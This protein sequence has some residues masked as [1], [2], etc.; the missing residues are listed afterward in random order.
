MRTIR[1]RTFF[2][3]FRD[4]TQHRKFPI[5]MT[6]IE[7]FFTIKQHSLAFSRPHASRDQ[8]YRPGERCVHAQRKLAWCVSHLISLA[9]CI[10]RSVIFPSASASASGPRLQVPCLWLPRPRPFLEAPIPSLVVV[11]SNVHCSFKAGGS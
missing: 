8:T 1:L 3:C 2:L 5:P 6:S 11:Q 10:Q 9:G 7:P 4:I